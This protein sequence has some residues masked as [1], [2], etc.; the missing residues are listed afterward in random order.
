MRGTNFRA[1]SASGEKM[2]TVFT[3]KSMLSIR[4]PNF[5]AHWAYAKR[6]S[7]LAEHIRDGLH[8][9]LSKRGNQIRFSKISCS[10]P[11]KVKGVKGVGFCKKNLISCLWTFTVISFSSVKIYEKCC[12]PILGS[13]LFLCEFQGPYNTFKRILRFQNPQKFA[14]NTLNILL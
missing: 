5:I 14:S 9:W 13:T 3:C 11:L 2:W 6:I 4:G 7:S 8:S 1:C 10:R 12:P